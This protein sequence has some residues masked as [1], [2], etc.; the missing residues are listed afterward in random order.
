V[1]A[2]RVTIQVGSTGWAKSPTVLPAERSGRKGQGELIAGRLVQVDLVPD[3]GISLLI[4]HPP[5]E[6]LPMSFDP[7]VPYGQTPG[8]REMGRGCRGESGL[9]SVDQPYHPPRHLHRAIHTDVLER[10][11]DGEYGRERTVLSG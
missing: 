9:D 5:E 4:G 11:L 10:Q 3:D 6:L 8:A 1:A 2:A 7:L